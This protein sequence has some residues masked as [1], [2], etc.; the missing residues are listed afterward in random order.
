MCYNWVK[1]GKTLGSLKQDTYCARKFLAIDII[2]FLNAK[3]N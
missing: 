2:F 3:I 1:L